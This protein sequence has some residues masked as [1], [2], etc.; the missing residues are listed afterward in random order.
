MAPGDGERYRGGLWRGGVSGCALWLDSKQLL[1]GSPG[2]GGRGFE[3]RIVDV[4]RQ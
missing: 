1:A 4:I 3:V 2:I